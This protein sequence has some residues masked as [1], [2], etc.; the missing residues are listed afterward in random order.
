[1]KPWPSD[2][3]QIVCATVLKFNRKTIKGHAIA[4]KC[5][6]CNEDVYVDSYSLEVALT[7][8]AKRKFVHCAR[9]ICIDCFPEYDTSEVLGIDLR[10]K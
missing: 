2:R 6:D 9:I 5:A 8:A 3:I 7:E 10:K 4:R 1:M